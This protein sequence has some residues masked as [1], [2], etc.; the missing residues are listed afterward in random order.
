MPWK[1]LLA[2]SWT[3]VI[4]GLCW[5]P[6]FY[7][8][9]IERGHQPLFVPN[10]DKLVHMGIFAVFAFLWMRVGTPGRRS[11]RVFGAGLGFAMLTE[12][13]QELPIVSRDA[14]VFD[15]VADTIGVLFG[16]A[17]FEMIRRYAEGRAV[18]TPSVETP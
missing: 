18:K 1:P 9:K 7:V 12:L 13:G 2:W 14:N 11:W 10:L 17:G 16:L 4:M 5:L 15:G 3:F 6:G 8:G